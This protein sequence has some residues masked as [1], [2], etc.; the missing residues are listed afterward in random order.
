MCLYALWSFEH[1]A[2]TVGHIDIHCNGPIHMYHIILDHPVPWIWVS[3][4]QT[5]WSNLGFIADAAKKVSIA[6]LL[7]N[8]ADS[9]IKILYTI[10]LK[11]STNNSSYLLALEAW[12]KEWQILMQLLQLET[13]GEKFDAC[14]FIELSLDQGEKDHPLSLQSVNRCACRGK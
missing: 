10:P 4:H 11:Y 3:L 8:W 2:V 6:S 14:I 1:H 5:W 7:A 12:Y 13:A 9:V